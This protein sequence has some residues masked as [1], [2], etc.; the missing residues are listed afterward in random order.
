M[1]PA[2]RGPASVPA[3]DHSLAPPV[4]LRPGEVPVACATCHDPKES[5]AML[6]AALPQFRP[7]GASGLRRIAISKAISAA[8]AVSRD[9]TTELGKLLL[10]SEPGWFV[11]LALATRVRDLLEMGPGGGATDGLLEAL[12]DGNPAVRRAAL[13]GLSVTGARSSAR[14]ILPLTEARDPFV[15]LEA[16][17]ALFGLRDPSSVQLLA[18]VSERPD[19]KG[20][21]RT[22]LALARVALISREWP[23]AAE[24]FRRGLELN[25]FAV[26]ALNDLGIA[27]SNQNKLAEGR[28]L[29]QQALEINPQFEAARRNLEQSEGI[30]DAP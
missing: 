20:E 23:E 24:R 18:A 14:A 26:P 6:A 28:R 22:Q 29:F 10:E 16:A 19:L 27:L 2:L 15:A 1:A 11:K 12:E 25:P 8:D 5:A 17:L 3:R 9:A 4:E 30:A 7:R 13:R 21:F